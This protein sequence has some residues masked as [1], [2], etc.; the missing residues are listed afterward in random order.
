MIIA[1]RTVLIRL[2]EDFGVLAKHLFAF[3][4]GEGHFGGFEELV[5]LC[6]GVAFGAF[7]PFPA[8]NMGL[9]KL[10]FDFLRG[11]IGIVNCWA[12]AC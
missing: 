10:S 12:S 3:F 2:V 4:A 6:L 5:V 11:K 8:C 7:E 9:V 1:V